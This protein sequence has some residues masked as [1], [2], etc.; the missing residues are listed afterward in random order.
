MLTSLLPPSLAAGFTS[1]GQAL[2]FSVLR[3]IRVGRLELT[4]LNPS[5][6]KELHTFG[7][8]SSA[9]QPV[10]RLTVKDPAVWW[11]LCGN[12][13]LVCTL[14]F[15]LDRVLIRWL[16]LPL[17]AMGEAYMSDS[18]ECDNLISLFT[19][20]RSSAFYPN[21]A[22]WMLIFIIQLYLRNWEYM[23][24]G[25]SLLQV[26]PKVLRVIFP[27][28]NTIAAAL[29]NASAHYDTSNDLFQGF[30]SPDMMYSCALWADEGES[31]E[32]AQI[33]KVHNIIHKAGIQ[34]DHHVLDIGC[35]WGTL[36]MEAVK[37]TGCRV[38]GLTLSVQQKE[39]AEQRIQAAGLSDRIEI[40]LCDYRKAPVPEGG[41]DRIVSVEMIEH[42]GQAHMKQYFAEIEQRLNKTDGAVVIQGITRVNSVCTPSYSLSCQVVRRTYHTPVS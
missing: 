38:T 41:Y 36:A 33:R 34:P 35:G 39:L 28:T 37:L 40:L 16:T 14:R 17:Q 42:V 19:V 21:S 6:P 29:G 1:S 5:G 27:P 30:L 32:T 13:D 3:S 15:L 2:I 25:Y 8:S 31:L 11:Q 22:L 18:I 4:V 12:I 7:D 23:G 24:T 20:S 10:V 9:A 26:F